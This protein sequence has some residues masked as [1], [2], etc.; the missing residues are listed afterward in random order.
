MRPSFST[1]GDAG[2]HLLGDD[3]AGD[4]DRV[5]DQLA[6]EREPHRPRDGDAGLLLRL[7]GGG[8]EVRGDDDRLE[9]RTAASRCTAPWR[10]RRCRR[11]RP[12]PRLRA[13]ASACSSTMPPRAALMIRTDG[14]TLRSA[15][16]PIRPTVSG[17]LGRW[18]VMK[19]LCRAARRGD[20]SWTPSWAA[21]A[22]LHVGVVGDDLHA[23][24]REPLRR[25]ARRSGRGRRCRRS[26]R[27]ARRRCTC[28]ASTRRP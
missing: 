9:A 26:C 24:R 15:S 20:S 13:S 2:A 25:R 17:V 19:S 1:S 6:A 22:A 7:V 16:S 8:A 12:G 18:T 4:V 5:G 28:C 27:A 11:R 23:E 14:L 3:P 10:R 21:R